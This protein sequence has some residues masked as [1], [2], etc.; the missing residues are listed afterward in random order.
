MRNWARSD[1]DNAGQEYWS[2]RAVAEHPRSPAGTYVR[3]VRASEAAVEDAATLLD[4]LEA[5]WQ[6]FPSPDNAVTGVGVMAARRL[7]DAHLLATWLGRFESRNPTGR[8]RFDERVA[9]EPE[10]LDLMISR[11]RAY[12]DTLAADSAIPVVPGETRQENRRQELRALSS[13]LASLTRVLVANGRAGEALRM[14]G[15][16]SDSVLDAELLVA[17]SAAHKAMGERSRAM[18]DL[19][20]A[21]AMD[22]GHHQSY[23]DSARAVLGAAFDNH[24]WD[25]RVGEA[26]DEYRSEL[27][28]RPIGQSVGTW[29]IRTGAG[30]D[31]RLKDVASGQAL[32]V[33][34]IRTNTLTGGAMGA[35]DGVAHGLASAGV[36]WIYLDA[37]VPAAGAT[38]SAA[39]WHED[40]SVYYDVTGEF[41]SA[42]APRFVPQYYVIDATGRVRFTTRDLREVNTFALAL[43]GR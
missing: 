15:E 23:A 2:K 28:S 30:A 12:A 1:F 9:A 8:V 21:A 11:L 27:L 22:E 3:S 35:A 17:R 7:G 32:V 16:A 18:T 26:R 20:R 25:R 31:Q 14:L 42:L 39:P 24:E 6:D 33:A 34:I 43:V 19:A 41:L 40:A 4:T 37:E 13:A 29:R 38:R 10:F 5:I 36:R